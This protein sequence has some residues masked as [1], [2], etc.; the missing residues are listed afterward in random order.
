MLYFKVKEMEDRI[1]YRVEMA[2]YVL[3]TAKVMM[4]GKRFLY[5]GTPATIIE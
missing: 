4:T 1:Q 5:E 2:E 3:E